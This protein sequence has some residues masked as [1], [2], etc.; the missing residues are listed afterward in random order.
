VTVQG[1]VVLIVDG[2][3]NISGGEIQLA[4]AGATPASLTI[5]MESGSMTLGDNGIVNSDVLP[6]AKRVAIVGTRNTSTSNSIQI[7]ISGTNPFYGVIYFPYLPITVAGNP[8]IYGSIVGQSVTF[9]GSPTIHYDMALRY[10]AS[11]PL[12]S[13]AAFTSLY[14]PIAAGNL[15]ETAG[16]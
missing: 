16:P 7:S 4:T 1:P 13:D 15:L 8:V 11:P 10:P 6:L 5:F 9:T 2:N 3:V 14:S 12:A